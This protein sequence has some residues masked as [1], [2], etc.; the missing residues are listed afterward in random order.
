M[1]YLF[2]FANLLH[3]HCHT[4][5]ADY[6]ALVDFQKCRIPGLFHSGGR[7]GFARERN[8]DE[9]LQG[10]YLFDYKAFTSGKIEL[11]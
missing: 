9:T 3:L 1:N 7:A 6:K 2:P 5:G 8:D 11:F 4:A 10:S